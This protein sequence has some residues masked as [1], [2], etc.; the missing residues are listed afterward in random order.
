VAS[1]KCQKFWEPE[2]STKL[3]EA[4]ARVGILKR[5]LSIRGTR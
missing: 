2:W 1:K 4:W 3:H 5:V